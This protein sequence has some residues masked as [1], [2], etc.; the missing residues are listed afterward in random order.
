MSQFLTKLFVEDIDGDN[1]ILADDLVYESDLAKETITA[2]KGMATDFASIP[3]F[4]TR[5]IHKNGLHDYGA[6]IHDFL[7]S[8]NAWNNREKCDRILLEAMICK[9]VGVIRRNL[10]Y[11]SVRAGGWKAWNAHAERIRDA[12]VKLLAS[13]IAQNFK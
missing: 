1:W 5:L 9:G 11:Y 3:T 13:S 2:P 7:Y 8:T 12:K 6:I 4:A 10:I